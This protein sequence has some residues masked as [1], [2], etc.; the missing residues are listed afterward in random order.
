MMNLTRMAIITK[1]IYITSFIFH[2]QCLWR[3]SVIARG[4]TMKPQELHFAALFPFSAMNRESEVAWAAK[5]AID[6]A[7]KYVN[8]NEKILQDF[9]LSMKPFDTKCEMAEGTKAFF[10]AMAE[11]PPKLMILGGVCSNVT[12]PIAEAVI[13]WKLIQLSYAN[14]EP[15]LSEREK[16]PT[17]FRTVP[18]EADFNPAK[19]K[20]LE[21]FNWTVVATIYQ[22]TPRFSIAHSRLIRDL[23]DLGNKLLLVANFANDPEQAVKDLRESGARIILGYFEEDV[24]VKVFCNVY[25]QKLFGSKYAWIL[26][27]WYADSWWNSTDL[28]NDCTAADIKEAS[29]GYLATDI[30]PLS[31]SEEKTI[32]GLTAKEYEDMYNLERGNNFTV[33]HGYAY[34]GV[35]V[36]ASALEKVINQLGENRSMLT[37]FDYQNDY[38]LQIFMEAMN[39]TDFVGVTGPVRFKDGNRLGTIMYEQMQ[40]G[41]EFKIGEYYAYSDEFNLSTEE[42][43]WIG[44]SPPIDQPVIYRVPRGISFVLY[45]VMCCLSY[46]G[47]MLAFM[48]LFFNMKFRKHRYIKMSSPYINNLIIIGGILCYSSIFVIGLDSPSISDF[49]FEMVCSA[50]SWLLA[51]GFTLAFGAMFS[52]TWRVH[53]IFTNLKMKKRVIRDRKLFTIVCV[54]LLVDVVVLLSWEIR[55]PLKRV[56]VEAREEIDPEGDDNVFVIPVMQ[57]CESVQMSVWLATI[58]VYKGVLMV[59]GCFL[60]WETRHVSIPALNDSK[61]IGMSVYNIVVACMIG[62]ALSFV[63]KNDP[64][65]AFGIISL[66]ILFCTTITLCLV[67]VPKILELRRD[68]TG[69]D[70]KFRCTS[71]RGSFKLTSAS[72]GM[73]VSARMHYLRVEN[74]K[75]RKALAE[76]DREVSVLLE[77]LGLE[78]P[79]NFEH[80][81]SYFVPETTVTTVPHT[82]DTDHNTITV[83][84]NRQG[85]NG[86]ADVTTHVYVNPMDHSAVNPVEY[87]ELAEIQLGNTSPSGE[88]IT[89][90]GHLSANAGSPFDHDN[91]NLAVHTQMRPKRKSR[92]ELQYG[93]LSNN[94]DVDTSAEVS[95]D[96]RS[97]LLED[98]NE[99]SE[100]TCALML[101]LHDTPILSDDDDNDDDDEDSLDDIPVTSHLETPY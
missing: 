67:F 98:Q 26:P 37:E 66:F 38:I 62:A 43:E 68:P 99:L 15:F 42:I 39:D 70:R 2:V 80:L 1:I 44:G 59:F 31:N 12:A 35:W 51:V 6:L 5:P 34:D 90:G 96:A 65:A 19:I 11:G 54:L 101:T 75:L 64:N 61:Y 82:K 85:V 79:N 100:Y 30:L 21:H 18:S 83:M 58:Y 3:D 49:A 25:K 40:D 4:H 17:F 81:N 60:A 84:D 14:T 32:S 23:E 33:L 57:H 69:E 7:I 45:I 63:I 72:S 27:G 41:K 78:T 29:N 76:K 56:K 97:R 13:W 36:V 9:E 48:F 94:E 89:N 91:G 20:L 16:Y 52:K 74:G 22:D 71:A 28:P 73:N 53:S 24:A 8:I 93:A 88:C 87:F 50:R 86:W 95:E 46:I 47:I 77:K 10:E 92:Q 55:D